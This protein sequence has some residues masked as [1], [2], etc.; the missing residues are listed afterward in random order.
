MA[1][2]R[3]LQ[4]ADFEGLL[5]A[6]DGLPVVVRLLDPPLHEFLPTRLELEQEMHRL[7]PLRQSITDLQE[8]SAQVETWE[9]HNPM[10]G[11][12][13]VR[14]GLME[15]D[16]YRMQVEA[17]LEAVV[18]PVKAGGDP[19]LEIMIPLVG[20]VEELSRMREM[21]EEEIDKVAKAGGEQLEVPIGHDDRAPPGR[22]DRGRAR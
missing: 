21:I 19:H 7:I 9:E 8:M 14:L 20:A 6:M 1:E 5:K 15:A 10:M 11:L 16:I 18:T 4:V 12:R 22:P 2:L 17:A 3:A 13:G